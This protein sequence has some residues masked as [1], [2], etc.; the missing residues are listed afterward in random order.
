M[1]RL[2]LGTFLTAIK[3]CASKYGFAQGRDFREMFSSFWYGYN[4]KD[5]MIVHIVGG[6]KNPSP[7]FVDEIN[8]IE[9][10]QYSGLGDNFAN[11]ER[12]IDSE[13]KELLVKLFDYLVSSD[14]TISEEMEVDLVNRT[15]KACFPGNCV[16][17]SSMMAGL[18]L[19][20][21]KHTNNIGNQKYVKEIN[22][23]YN[24]ECGV[25]IQNEAE[26]QAQ[27]SIIDNLLSKN[28][29]TD[30]D[31]EKTNSI[32]EKNI[33][34]AKEFLIKHETESSMIP[35]C[36]MA[37]VYSPHHNHIRPMYTEFALLPKCSRD[38]IL[39]QCNEEDLTDVTDLH[40]YEGLDQLCEDMSDYSL[41]S[42]RYL[43]AVQQYLPKAFSIYAG[44][45]IEH[46]D[47]YS[48]IRLYKS[49]TNPFDMGPYSSLDTYIA[50]YLWMK[51]HR[52]ETNALPPM[53]YLWS[54]EDFASCSGD[55]LSFWLCQ[56][57]IA[58]CN[59]LYSYIN[60][61]NYTCIDPSS[62][63]RQEDL[64]YFTLY[65]IY[66]YYCCHTNIY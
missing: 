56:F 59:N 36:Q 35:L 15:T 21:V 61:N 26:A 28:K 65:A 6:R 14:D 22:A 29:H 4:P 37:Y 1:S 50:D 46:H 40:L 9:S 17:L 19:Y 33:I 25:K 12:R 54:K 2:C 47:M 51:E 23:I 16:N 24:S 27:E 18:F 8:K 55:N 60:A 5:D 44:E 48:F 39:A 34:R 66:E 53:D 20:V 45:S 43:Y 58:A 62:A 38:Y 31:E 10:S 3:L 13:G 57:I 41:S 32:S 52:I 63:E 11:I 49:K 42:E 30:D 64:F 7:S